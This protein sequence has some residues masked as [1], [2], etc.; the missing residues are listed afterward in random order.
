MTTAFLAP[1]RDLELSP[2]VVATNHLREVKWAEHVQAT[3]TLERE[4]TRLLDSDG[5]TADALVAAFLRP[6][7]L[8]RDYARGMGTLYTAAYRGAEGRAD[9]FW[10]GI[11]WR[12]SFDRF[13][14]GTRTIRLVESTA[15]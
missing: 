13:Q 14:P 4:P 5:T 15:A 8:Q 11:E 1:D 3:H 12:Q 2:A 10:P 6:P 7:L 9:Y